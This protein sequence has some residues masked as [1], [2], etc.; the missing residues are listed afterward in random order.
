MDSIASIWLVLRSSFLFFDFVLISRFLFLGYFTHKGRVNWPMKTVSE[1]FPCRVLVFI[2]S[3]R[4]VLLLN[5]IDK[6]HLSYLYFIPFG[7]IFEM[8]CI[9]SVPPMFNM[10]KVLQ[11]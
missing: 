10:G 8:L 6:I 5:G 2:V 3:H 7:I 4:V 9:V 11:E 1:G